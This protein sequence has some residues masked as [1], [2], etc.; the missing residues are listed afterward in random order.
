MRTAILA[1]LSVALLGIGWTDP[2]A[3]S[4][5]ADGR[6]AIEGTVVDAMSPTEAVGKVSV[7]LTTVEGEP[8]QAVINDDRGM[9][10]FSDV[11][12]GR[13]A[14]VVAKPGNV[15]TRYGA[16]RYDLP[17]APVVLS[18]AHRTVDING[19][20]GPRR[21]HRGCGLRRR[22]GSHAR[23][24]SVRAVRLSAGDPEEVGF[25]EGALTLSKTDDSGGFRVY[26]LPA[27]RYLVAARPTAPDL[28]RVDVFH[29]NDTNWQDGVAIELTAG[30]EVDATNI[31]AELLPTGRIQGRV[32]NIDAGKTAQVQ[33]IPGGLIPKV[34][35]QDGRFS[36]EN[37]RPGQY[38]LVAKVASETSTPLCG[39]TAVVTGGLDISAE[40]NSGV[41]VSQGR[42]GASTRH[43]HKLRRF[44]RRKGLGDSERRRSSGCYDGIPESWQPIHSPRATSWKIE[45]LSIKS[46]SRPDLVL[47]SVSINGTAVLSAASSVGRR[48][49][50]RGRYSRIIPSHQI[51]SGTL[52]DSSSRPVAGLT[53]VLFDDGRERWIP[54]SRRVLTNVSATDGTFQFQAV[55][56]GQ[57]HLAVVTSFEPED[58]ADPLFVQYLKPSS[59]AFSLTDGEHKIQTLLVPSN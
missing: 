4:S 43:F 47:Q 23:R 57:W 6:G 10:H 14:I 50:A 31:S 29:P 12:F 38:R 46:P 32:L 8:V 27:G 17:G 1:G 22:R 5:V 56:A 59:I 26:G 39:E 52:V 18:E 30:S 19:A 55:P 2:A 21:R 24:N 28:P 37:L 49:I 48:P 33:L 3:Q 16:R 53:V 13:Y 15:M 11:P 45:N 41:W 42:G 40:V 7:R 35:A 58:A 25:L 44:G 54:L 51:V 34:V 20:D 36:Y 9:F